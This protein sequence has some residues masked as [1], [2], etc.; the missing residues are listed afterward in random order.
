MLCNTPSQFF[1][2][3]S[4]MSKSPS[5]YHAA[6]PLDTLHILKW[7]ALASLKQTEH[8]DRPAAPFQEAT[9][10]GSHRHSL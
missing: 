9:P 4:S 3:Q 8:S 10:L 6:L 7:P 1:L 5:V 2:Q